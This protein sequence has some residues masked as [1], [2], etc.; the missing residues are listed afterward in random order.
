MA[1]KIAAPD[2]PEVVAQDSK[3]VGDDNLEV[4]EPTAELR[5]EQVDAQVSQPRQAENPK[6]NV[7]E[8]FVATDTV[9]TDPSS[10][11]AVQVP[12]AGRGSL[13]LPIHR[14]AGPLVEDV[15]AKADA[16]AK[17]SVKK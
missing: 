3:V 17:K 7:H 2:L 9:I 5:K 8:T 13:D 11:L 15:F 14:L 10:P 16:E 1:N 4:R 12:D 6:V